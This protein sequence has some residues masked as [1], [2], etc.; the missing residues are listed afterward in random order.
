[1]KYTG[2]GLSFPSE[3]CLQNNPNSG[4]PENISNQWQ[5][6]GR[7]TISGQPGYEA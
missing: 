1:M 3:L 7:S 6:G 4:L 5:E 2:L